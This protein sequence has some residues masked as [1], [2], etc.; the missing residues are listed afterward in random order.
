MHPSGTVISI[1][2]TASPGM[3][4]DHWLGDLS[5]SVNPATFTLNA[6][7][8]ITAVFAPDSY[9]LAYAAGDGGSVTGEAQQTVVYGHDGTAVTAQA[10][11]GHHFVRWS[12]GS[13]LNPR[14]DTDVNADLNVTAEFA[15]DTFTLTYTAGEHGSVTGPTTQT[16]DF[17]A[18]GVEVTAVPGTGYHFMQWSDGVL[19][20][21][22]TEAGVIVDLSVTA[23]FAINVYSLAYT[24][25]ADG[26]LSGVVSQTVNHGGTGT[27]VTA[28]PSG[29]C[30]FVQWSDGL[31]TATRTDTNVSGNI[32]VAAEFGVGIVLH[33]DADS[34][35]AAPDGA[36]WATAY[37]N[38]QTAVDAAPVNAQVWVAD[39]TYTALT[40][41]VLNMRAAVLLYGGFAGNEVYRN[42][43]DWNVH[44]SVIDGQE[45]RRCV[46]G[47]DYAALDGFTVTRGHANDG[48]GIYNTGTAPVIAHCVFA[49]NLATTNGGGLGNSGGS[50]LIEDCIFQ[51]NTSQ[52]YGGGIYSDGEDG[53]TLKRCVLMQNTASSINS[54]GYGGGIFFGGTALS[55]TDCLVANNSAVF[56]GGLL[57][58]SGTLAI[59]NSVFCG[60]SATGNAGAM[61]GI[62]CTAAV[63]NCVFVQNSGEDGGALYTS[64]REWTLSNCVFQKNHAAGT[65][66]AI[67]NS[68]S[69]LNLYNC[70]FTHNSAEYGGA[71]HSAH[72]EYLTNCILWGDTATAEGP[73]IHSNNTSYS[74]L[75][76]YSCIQGG[77]AGA[78]NIDADPLFVNADSGSLYLQSRSP[79]LDTGTAAGA[80]ATDML[81]R[82]HPADGGVD[83]GAY[84]G[85]TAEGDLVTLTLQ[86]SPVYGGTLWPAAGTH[87]YVRGERVLLVATPSGMQFADWTGDITDRTPIISVV[88]DADKIITAEFALNVVYVTA[89]GKGTPDGKSWATAYHD[90]QSAVDA[91][92]NDNSGEVWVAEG[93]YTATAGQVLALKRGVLLYGG[94]AGNENSRDQ[95]DWSTHASV[96][97]GE[98]T[99]RC[100]VGADTALLDGFTVTRGNASQGGGMHNENTSPTVRN[101]A[102]THNIAQNGAAIAN[103]YEA[104]RPV[105][106]D[107]TFGDNDAWGDG[108][109]TY[110]YQAAPHITR[111]MFKHNSA[112]SGGGIY[113]YTGSPLISDCSFIHNFAGE[114]GG[115]YSGKAYTLT[116]DECVF[117]ANAATTGD[118]G[119]MYDNS[120]KSTLKNCLFLRNTA[121]GPRGFGGGLRPAE[122]TGTSLVN[123]T[124][125]QNAAISGGAMGGDTMYAGYYPTPHLTNCILWNDKAREKPELGFS[126][127][128]FP[129]VTHCCIQGALSTGGNIGTDPLFVDG[130]GGSVQLRV[131]SPCL[132][133]GTATGAPATDLLGRARPAG[134]GVDMGAYEGAAT[135]ADLVT[136]TIQMSP[137]EGGHAQP[138][139][140][141]HT[142]VRGETAWLTALPLGM[143]SIG[144]TGDATE[145]SQDLELVMDTDKTV[146]AEFVPNVLYV[147]AAQ[148]GTADGRSWATA[149]KTIQQARNAAAAD[150]GGEV[151]VAT[152]YYQAPSETGLMMAPGVSLY[153]GFEGTETARDQRDWNAH[154]AAIIGPG[155]YGFA[156][157]VVG[158][159]D[160]VLDGFVITKG[161]SGMFIR[162]CS[163][164]VA[165]CL[166]LDN[167]G[168]EGGGI[169]NEG[170]SPAIVN[171]TFKQNKQG[172]YA[173]GMSNMGGSPTITNCLFVDNTGCGLY[174]GSSAATVTGCTFERNTY[175][176]MKNEFMSDT[177]RNVTVT[178]CIFTGNTFDGGMYSIAWAPFNSRLSVAN[179]VFIRN[180]SVR[181]GGVYNNAVPAT[182]VNCVFSQNTGTGDG[183]WPAQGG[184]YYQEGGTS[185]MT[186]CIL[187]GNTAAEGSEVFVAT[188]TLTAKYSCMPPGFGDAGTLYLDPLFVDATDGN[189]RLQTGS[190]CI[191]TGTAADA[192]AT[193]IEGT[194]RPQGR[195]F[196]MGA[197]ER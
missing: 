107:C 14:N 8:S 101:C 63:D 89:D 74:S 87:Q 195:G 160:A 43:R 66:G 88:M 41:P 196:D 186:N 137:S 194:P 52:G 116:L 126:D 109:A 119:G 140:G 13:A 151:W 146:T 83:M 28:V 103:I 48:G 130:A 34:S 81:G 84:E 100:V 65:G 2:A 39:G 159:D 111:C 136:L 17:G 35:A 78:G 32:T 51:G 173:A 152:G 7:A 45:T 70:T 58:Y 162:N 124:F 163:P 131:D 155:Q 170:G 90:I 104:A 59:M 86:A 141:T 60:N 29:G 174:N 142:F 21:A 77:F 192:P 73:E 165:N 33:V 193:D 94:F 139:A 64:E 10:S 113:A 127:T 175:G 149:F 147:N 46:V 56:G 22:R 123:C 91:A 144:W 157:A 95:R 156:G 167:S 190:P 184:G 153:G 183:Y 108:G 177:E 125:T 191:D 26:T 71:L 76:A 97:D 106:A 19:T 27:T 40:D 55:L 72:T 110:S 62:R 5:G 96:I 145:S 68:S 115:L 120:Q 44:K 150:S 98:N 69:S 3:H 148:T 138:E 31:I 85:A 121:L 47:A 182:F 134:A 166:F 161:Q 75:A 122:Y 132:D 114:G 112:A 168:V 154:P 61:A 171:C 9:T 80:P 42:Q 143:R 158:A 189:V 30:H 181:G 172:M 93:T 179:S 67:H 57:S 12:D 117:V 4:F 37:P 15:V 18:D 118:G 164:R 16:V 176:G 187:W 53:L 180:S 128:F 1:T 102:F 82:P 105:I 92:P 6:G 99:R 54:G 36:T 11:T 185:S 188:G 50:P 197:Y 23:S 135:A 178:N 24:A 169:S 25:G 49:G 38:I 20:S 129:L 79:C 133:T